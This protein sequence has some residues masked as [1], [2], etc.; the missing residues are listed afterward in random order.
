MNLFQS[1]YSV[2]QSCSYGYAPSFRNQKY[3]KNLLITNFGNH[4]KT[5]SYNTA[6]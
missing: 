6:Y 1:F 5:A 2:I 3:K 4:F